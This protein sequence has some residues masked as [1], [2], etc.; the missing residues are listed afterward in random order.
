[1]PGTSRCSIKGSYYNTISCF[2]AWKWQGFFQASAPS[3]TS[4]LWAYMWH[5]LPNPLY[6]APIWGLS[7]DPKNTVVQEKGKRRD[8]WRCDLGRQDFWVSRRWRVMELASLF[9]LLREYANQNSTMSLTRPWCPA[10]CYGVIVEGHSDQVLDISLSGWRTWLTLEW[11]FN[12]L[13]SL[14]P[15]YL[16]SQTLV[17]SSLKWNF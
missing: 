2:L 17:S 1:M 3:A 6:I 4:F 9:F 15:V 12:F 16:T 14:K 5:T 8:I 7:C 11:P 10:M 13:C